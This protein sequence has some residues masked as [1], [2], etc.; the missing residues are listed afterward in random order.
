MNKVILC[1]NV[2]SDPDCGHT[3]GGTAYARVSLATNER[4]KNKDG[5][6]QEKT[7]WHRLQF[8]KRQAEVVAQY[9]RKGDKL[10]IEGRIEY[11]QYED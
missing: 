2:G 4:W 7:S 6:M 9:V 8:W 11:G 10:L 1:G 3:N 5:E